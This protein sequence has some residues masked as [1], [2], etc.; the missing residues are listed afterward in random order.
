[1]WAPRSR[2]EIGRYFAG[3]LDEL[4]FGASL[5]VLEDGPYFDR[6]LDRVDRPQIGVQGWFADY[7]SASNFI[8]PHFG[9]EP[10]GALSAWNFTDLCDPGARRRIEQALAAQGAEAHEHW[11]A[12]DRRIVDLAPAVPLTSHRDVVFV[13][14]RVGN[15]QHHPKW[16][17]LL[18][19]LWVR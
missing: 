5:R 9:C 4:G 13:S 16:L 8:E 1:M 7:L 3:L 10:S 15:V 18:D 17:T 6:L 19:Q 2:R 12:A 11:A 14:E